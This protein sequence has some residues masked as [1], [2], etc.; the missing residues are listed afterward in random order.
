M[1]SDRPYRKALTI[2]AA[3]EEVARFAGI[4]FDPVVAQAFLSIDPEIWRQIRER[5]HAEVTAIE[6]QVRKALR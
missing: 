5:V 2:D 6:D 1:T 4:Q 3:R